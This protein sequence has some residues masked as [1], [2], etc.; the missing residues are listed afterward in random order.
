MNWQPIN[1]NNCARCGGNHKNISCL[2]LTRP[3]EEFTHW[4][5]CPTTLEPI[6]VRFV[7]DDFVDDD[8]GAQP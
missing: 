5:Q 1:I 8:Q 4:A 3:C 6:M 7:D 2:Q